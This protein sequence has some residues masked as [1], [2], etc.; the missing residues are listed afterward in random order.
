MHRRSVMAQKTP[1]RQGNE[2]VVDEFDCAGTM[3]NFAGIN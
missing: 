2:A 1:Q 3:A